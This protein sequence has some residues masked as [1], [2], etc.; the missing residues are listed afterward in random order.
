MCLKMW[1]KGGCSHTFSFTYVAAARC[2]Q[3]KFFFNVI[4]LSKIKCLFLSPLALYFPLSLLKSD[5]QPYSVNIEVNL[6]QYFNIWMH[7]EDCKVEF[8]CHRFLR[9]IWV[10]KDLQRS[11]CHC[12]PSPSLQLQCAHFTSPIWRPELV[13]VCVPSTV[14]HFTSIFLRGSSKCNI[15]FISNVFSCNPYTVMEK[16]V[17][18]IFP[19]S[20]VG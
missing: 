8:I 14:P 9:I 17:V 19:F 13:S 11:S 5:M 4:E 20:C 2:C 1:M 12:C 18:G 7:E 15:I 16:F 3:H 6:V 10:G